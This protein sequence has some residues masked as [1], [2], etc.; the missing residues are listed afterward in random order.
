LTYA[1]HNPEATDALRAAG[2]LPS[3]SYVCVNVRRWDKSSP[4]FPREFGRAVGEFCK[5]HS[6]T[7]VFLVMEEELDNA[8]SHEIAS[9]TGMDCVFLSSADGIDAIVQAVGG[10]ELVVSM[11]FHALVFAACTGTPLVGISYNPKVDAFL[12]ELGMEEAMCDVTD[13]DSKRFTGILSSVYGDREGIS[14]RLEQRIAPLREAAVRNA[15]I[16]CELL[17]G[18]DT[19]DGGV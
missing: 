3:G 12:R 18:Q 15:Q 17:E 13:F 9:L 4:S 10:A 11:R 6:L 1:R 5:S 14:S 8:I 16:V 7:P 19:R 2:K